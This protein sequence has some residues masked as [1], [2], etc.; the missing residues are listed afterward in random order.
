M[1]TTIPRVTSPI[2]LKGVDH[3]NFACSNLERTIAFWA[4]LGVKCTLNLHLHNPER[5]HA[6]FSMGE[7]GHE[8]SFSYWWW[9]DRTLTP[10]QEHDAFDHA[11]FY[12]LAFHVDTED[13]LDEMHALCKERGIVVSEIMGKHI[14]DKS[15]YFR[16][17]DGIQFEFACPVIA[18]KGDVD[19]D[20]NGTLTPV[21]PN[22]MIGNRRV[23]GPIHFE[24]RYK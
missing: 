7:D 11:G 24:T 3:I 9:P 13:E 10:A 6:F 2:R 17:P 23:D 19:H 14:F 22:V 8:S 20:G 15:F 12:H 16:D 21:E 5:N 18:L 1:A 4:Q